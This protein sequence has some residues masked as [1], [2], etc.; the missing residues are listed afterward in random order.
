MTDLPIDVQLEIL[1]HKKQLKQ[2][3]LDDW[4]LGELESIRE[5]CPHKNKK[6]VDSWSGETYSEI[7]G[8]CKRWFKDL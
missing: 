6:T 7:C 5:N 4:Y 1:E 2:D 8:D 3:E